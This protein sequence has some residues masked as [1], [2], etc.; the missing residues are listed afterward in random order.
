MKKILNKIQECNKINKKYYDRILNELKEMHG[1]EIIVILFGSRVKGLQHEFSDRDLL[2][3]TSSKEI[4]D[5]IKVRSQGWLGHSIDAKIYEINEAIERIQ[6]FDTI[7]LD[8]FHEGRLILD[9]LNEYKTLKKKV[10]DYIKE[11]GI[12]KTPK[13]WFKVEFLNESK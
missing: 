2:I 4:K 5:E 11:K 9:G 3:I 12:T 6:E 8:A 1:H 10:E 13:G 7:I